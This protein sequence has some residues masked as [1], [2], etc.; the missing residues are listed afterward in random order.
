MNISQFSKYDLYPFIIIGIDESGSICYKNLLTSKLYPKIRV[1][2][3]IS[4]YTNVGTSTGIKCGTLCSEGHLFL[5]Y[6]DIAQTKLMA[7]LPIF[8][9]ECDLVSDNGKF[10]LKKIEALLSDDIDGD[11]SA[12]RRYINQIIKNS[13]RARFLTS[14]TSRYINNNANKPFVIFNLNDAI[15]SVID[16]LNNRFPEKKFKI[17]FHSDSDFTGFCND[18]RRLLALVINAITT[19]LILSSKNAVDVSLQ[20]VKDRAVLEV[21]FDS[22][23]DISSAYFNNSQIVALTAGIFLTDKKDLRLE[24]ENGLYK[25]TFEIETCSSNEF[26]L[27]ENNLFSDDANEYMNLLFSCVDFDLK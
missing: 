15:K 2:A 3:K 14:F 24:K 26:A 7:V 12:Q 16:I 22:Q 19:S 9:A 1:G 8:D 4:N 6:N 10:Y 20:T 21:R 25:F 11:K 27:S 23:V 13:E 17:S 18:K 5:I